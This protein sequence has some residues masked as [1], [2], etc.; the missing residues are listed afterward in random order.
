MCGIFGI[1]VRE[2]SRFTLHGVEDT[3]TRLFKLSESRGK[4]AAGVSCIYPNHICICKGAISATDMIHTNEYQSLF[5]HNNRNSAKKA[6]GTSLAI[7]GHSRLVTTGTQV[8]HRNNQPVINKGVVGIHNGI[9]VNDEELWKEHLLLRQSEVD[10]EVIAALLRKFFSEFRS[11]S[12]AAQRT[13]GLIKGTASI[14]FQFNDLDQL[15]LSTNNGSLYLCTSD[16]DSLIFASEHY[17]L[18]QLMKQSFARKV[19]KHHE[20]RQVRPGQ[21]YLVGLSDTQLTKFSL[22][23]SLLDSTA[24]KCRDVPR[25]IKDISLVEKP[26]GMPSYSFSAIPDNTLKELR[27]DFERSEEAV[28]GLRR[29][30]RCILPETFPGI[31]FDEE[32]VCSVCLNYKYQMVAGLEALEQLVALHRKP[33]G[34][35]DCLCMLSG[36]RDSCYGLHFVKKVL[37]LNPVTF[38]YDWGMVTDIARRNISRMCSKLGVENILI[39]ADINTKRRHIAANVKAWLKRP[40]LGMVPLF[41][42]GDK[43]FFYYANQIRKQHE[44][45]MVFYCT[46]RRL[47]KTLFKSGFC[48][49]QESG[50]HAGTYYVGLGE[51]L[52]LFNYYSRQILHNPAYVN[53]SVVDTLFAFWSA[54]F[55]KHDMIRIYDYILWDEKTIEDTLLNEYEWEVDKGTSSTWRIGD[56]TAAFYNLIYHTVAGFSENDTMLSNMIREEM[57]TREKALQIAAD[58]NRPRFD[59]IKWYCDIIGIDFESTIKRITEIPKHYAGH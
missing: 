54:Y 58:L 22:T 3:F 31:T 21:G 36:G 55:H 56:G 6:F 12:H 2:N 26:G 57:V 39:S 51:K 18:R 28:R 9:I 53:C 17:F 46:N 19:L 13:F 14:A 4:E 37:G 47:E 48:G 8:F 1:V 49:V 50:S 45:N 33:G 40:D 30:K 7:I 29:C 52:K 15:L 38:T 34:Q 11:L 16:D 25:E 44:V 43:Q 35:V 20:I 5:K 41:M 23:E 59:S 10:S 42:A 32:G 24:S 27:K